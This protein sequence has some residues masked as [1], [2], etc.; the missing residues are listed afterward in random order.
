MTWTAEQSAWALVN[1]LAEHFKRRG[2]G[3]ANLIA[4]RVVS[5]GVESALAVVLV[6]FYVALDDARQEWA[7]R[8]KKTPR[9]ASRR[10]SGGSSQT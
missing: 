1:L 9:G 3:G 4:L 10:G 5:E 2:F 6:A 8:H 7:H